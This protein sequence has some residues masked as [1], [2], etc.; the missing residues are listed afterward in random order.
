MS[1]RRYVE[2]M[3]AEAWL[4]DK[5]NMTR[6]RD[7]LDK[8]DLGLPFPASQAIHAFVG[9]EPMSRDK[10]DYARMGIMNEDWLE[11]AYSGNPSPQ[12]LQIRQQL[13]Q[14]FA[15]VKAELIKMFGPVVP[16]VRHQGPIRPGA[17]K[18]NVLSWTLNPR[19]AEEL[20]GIRRLKP[21][22]DQDVEQAIADFL[23]NGTVFFR[24][25]HYKPDEEWPGG[26]NLYDRDMDHITGIGDPKM[27]LED[28][29]R[30]EFKDLQ[31]ER[32]EDIQAM[33]A[34][35]KF[36]QSQ[37]T[38]LEYVVWATDRA[39]QMEFIIRTV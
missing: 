1:F 17:K 7:L 28:T 37:S 8:A 36:I 6:L 34:K 23:K 19:F 32:N 14:H 38:S 5:D 26:I 3:D 27:S 9:H 11:D 18:R 24:G 10:E 39:N 13:Q 4:K 16:L 25:H 33:E 20:A 31:K 30:R 22:T 29:L 15:P 35:R 2:N 12:G 21:I